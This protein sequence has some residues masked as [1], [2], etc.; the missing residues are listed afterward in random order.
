[1]AVGQ[2]ASYDQCKQ[3]LLKLSYFEDDTK[4][5]LT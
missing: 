1:M 2:L 5:H 3:L 4:T